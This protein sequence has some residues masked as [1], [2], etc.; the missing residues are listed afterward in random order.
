[1]KCSS[2]QFPVM[3]KHVDDSVLDIG[4]GSIC[5]PFLFLFHIFNPSFMGGWGVFGYSGLSHHPGLT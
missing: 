1:M 5:L 2:D 4:P 3:G